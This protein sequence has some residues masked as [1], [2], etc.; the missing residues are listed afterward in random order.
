MTSESKRR[1]GR[2]KSGRQEAPGWSRN[3]GWRDISKC[4]CRR[5]HSR[6][7]K[8]SGVLKGNVEDASS[9]RMQKRRWNGVTPLRQGLPACKTEWWTGLKDPGG[10][11][12][13]LLDSDSVWLNA[14]SREE[15][16]ENRFIRN[17]KIRIKRENVCVFYVRT[18]NNS[19][20]NWI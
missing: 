20:D 11:T 14:E 3:V 12:W 17:V 5:I 6:K 9:E 19:S 7:E 18:R 16:N 15:E 8:K 10:I 13:E 4:Q 1:R 2:K